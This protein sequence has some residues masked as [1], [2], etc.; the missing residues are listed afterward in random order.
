MVSECK[1]RRVLSSKLQNNFHEVVQAA[2]FF[3]VSVAFVNLLKVK[4][5]KQKVSLRKNEL[6][7]Q[8]F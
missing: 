8:Q 3:H 5:I 6:A 2:Q 7:D 4:I 1:K